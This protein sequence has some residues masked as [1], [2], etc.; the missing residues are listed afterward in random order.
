[1]GGPFDFFGELSY[2]D[3]KGVAEQQYQNRQYLRNVMMRHG[4]L[5]LA[6]EWWHFSLK[7]EPYPDT[8]FTFPVSTRSLQK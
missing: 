4:F 2:P 5:P 7:D 1:M 8:Y 6:E 3:Y